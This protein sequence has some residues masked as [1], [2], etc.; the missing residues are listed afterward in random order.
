MAVALVLSYGEFHED[1]PGNGIIHKSIVIATRSNIGVRGLDK[2]K[3][4][5]LNHY[6]GKNKMSD[7]LLRE[8]VDS[9]ANEV[10][11]RSEDKWTLSKVP[12]LSL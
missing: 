4:T 1:N 5:I 6:S 11:L 12:C 7:L 9:G 10:L 2:V 8:L 3:E